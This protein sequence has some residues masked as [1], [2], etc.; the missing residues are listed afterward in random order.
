MWIP[1]DIYVAH[2][3]WQV[4]VATHDYTLGKEHPKYTLPL[5]NHLQKQVR[6]ETQQPK[7]APRALANTTTPLTTSIHHESMVLWI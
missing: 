3:I 7:N 1:I 2:S 5:Q 4:G 6:E